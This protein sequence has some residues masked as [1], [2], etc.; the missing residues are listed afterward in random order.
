MPN[1]AEDTKVTISLY[2]LGAIILF[3]VTATA[4]VI[5]F[6]THT[7]DRLAV[8]EVNCEDQ[9]ARLRQHDAR[10]ASQDVTLKKIETDVTWIRAILEKDE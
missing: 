3:L 1:I 2:L 4:A 5:S 9:E 7:E 6:K 8:I 10:F